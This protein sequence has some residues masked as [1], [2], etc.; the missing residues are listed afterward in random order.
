MKQGKINLLECRC[1][2]RKRQT[3]NAYILLSEIENKNKIREILYISEAILELSILLF[4]IQFM[5][6]LFGSF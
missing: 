6:L 2:L 1:M 4:N 3:D 5:L